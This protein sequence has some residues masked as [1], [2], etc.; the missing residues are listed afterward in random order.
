MTLRSG[1]EKKESAYKPGSVVDSHSSGMR[2]ATHL[3]QP[4]RERCGPHL[5]GFPT[6]SPIWPCSEWGFPCRGRLP[7]ARCAL[8][9]PFH[10]CRRLRA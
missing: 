1:L 7:A 9:A 2:V 6:C 3:K 8:T 4:T 5:A 10:P